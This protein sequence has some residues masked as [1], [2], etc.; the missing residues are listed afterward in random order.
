[1]VGRSEAVWGCV[2]VRLSGGCGGGGGSGWLVPGCPSW[3]G[4]CSVLW[5]ES[6]SSCSSCLFCRCCAVG[7]GRF[8]CACVSVAA[9]VVREQCGAGGG[10]VW[11]VGVESGRPVGWGGGGWVGVFGLVGVGGWWG[12]FLDVGWWVG[13]LGL[14]NIRTSWFGLSWLQGTCCGGLWV[15][16]WRFCGAAGAC[17][18]HAAVDFGCGGVGF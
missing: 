4:A 10:V 17:G 9:C 3:F 16:L 13:V 7:F 1:M 12:W 6:S 18:A 5:V 14:V 11:V 8:R 15:G 2:A